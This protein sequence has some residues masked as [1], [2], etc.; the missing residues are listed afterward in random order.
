VDIATKLATLTT[1]DYAPSTLHQ[2]DFSFIAEL[3]EKLSINIQVLNT[4]EIPFTRIKDCSFIQLVDNI[5]PPIMGSVCSFLQNDLTSFTEDGLHGR[6]DA[7]MKIIRLIGLLSSARNTTSDSTLARHRPDGMLFHEGFPPL[8]IF[9]EKAEDGQLSEAEKDLNEKIRW[10]PHYDKLNFVVIAIAG[11]IVQFAQI[12]QQRIGNEISFNLKRE[13]D[14]LA[15]VQAAINVGR[16]AL[17]VKSSR[18]LYRLHLPMNMPNTDNDQRRKLVIGFKGVEKT[19]LNLDENDKARL[20][21]FYEATA[22]IPYIEKLREYTKS[23]SS[24]T[25]LKLILTPVG[26]CRQPQNE[27]ELG[28]A[29][30]CICSALMAIHKLGWAHNDIRWL[31]IICVKDEWILIDCEYVSKFGTKLPNLKVKDPQT[32]ISSITSDLYQLGRLLDDF[33]DLDSVGNIKALRNNL[34]KDTCRDFDTI[35]DIQKNNWLSRHWK[36]H[37]TREQEDVQLEER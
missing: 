32:Q 37:V 20:L 15:C 33:V 21:S 8:V 14:R 18:M 26:V 4:Y 28:N 19:F 7:L 36:A 12:T 6:D 13:T 30:H 25:I 16:W 17:W 27:E 31:N 23:A 22:N 1:K 11:N 35:I 3:P 29:F 2:K 9:E 34:T 10:L 5:T 24:P